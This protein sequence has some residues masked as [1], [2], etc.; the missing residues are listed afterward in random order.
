MKF[1]CQV[2]PTLSRGTVNWRNI[3]KHI[4]KLRRQIFLAKLRGQENELRRLQRKMINSRG[5]L[6]WS[7]R[8]VTSINRGKKTAGTDKQVYLTP[9]RRLALFRRLEVINLLEWTPSPVRRIDL[10]RPGKS[11]RPLGIPNITDR[12]VQAVCKNALEPEWEALFEHGSYGFRP[13]RSAHDAM[14]RIWRVVS[15]KKRQWVLDA[16]ILGCFNNIAHEPLL[17]QITNFP[18]KCLVERWLKAGYFKNDIFHPTELGTPQGGIISPLLAN[19]A[20]HGMEKVLNVRYHKHGYIRTECRFVPVRYADDFVILCNSEKDAYEAKQILEVW[21]AERGM[22]FSPDK[23]HVRNITG[24]FDFLGWNFRLFRTFGP[25]KAWKRAKAELVTLV[26]PSSKSVQS[27]MGRIRSLWRDYIGKSAWLLI[28]KLNPLIKGWANYH[29]YVNSNKTF[30]SL[31]HFMYLQAIRFTKR[32]H[33]NKSWA[34]ILKRYFSKNI[35]KRKRKTGLFTESL[36][37]WTFS[38]KG[39]FLSQ[40]RTT[41]LENYESIA[42]GKNPFSSADKDYFAERKSKA[43]I[44]KDSF[45]N[46]LLEKQGG[47]CPLCEGFLVTNDWDEPLH[48]HHLVP[49]ADGGTD[50]ISNLMLLHEECHYSVHRDDLDKTVLEAR[51]KALLSRKL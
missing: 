8:K 42:Y 35:V 17:S 25:K 48:V 34:W 20:L 29:K 1:R 6:L 36:S 16:D 12:V 44:R 28:T 11:P 31:D 30:R 15:K 47:F 4:M 41:S 45:Q 38:E 14:A 3:D 2:T 9:E 33:S 46:K 23:T 39:F 24:G 26:Q 50:S 40:F 7:I 5:N 51:L 19:I 49:R 10:P 18:A 37:N 32:Q 13:A 43:I 27:I 21:L 22:T